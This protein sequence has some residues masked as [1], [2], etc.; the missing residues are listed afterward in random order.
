MK[1]TA[2]LNEK[3]CRNHMTGIWDHST[4]KCY[5]HYITTKVCI[6]VNM[7]S[8]EPVSWYRDGC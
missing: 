3:M 2:K 1:K 5:Y 4:H 6:V 8:L 7:T